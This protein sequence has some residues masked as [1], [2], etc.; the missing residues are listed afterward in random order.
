MLWFANKLPVV[1]CMQSLWHT[2][3]PLNCIFSRALIYDTHHGIS[4]LLQCDKIT[5]MIITLLS[6]HKSKEQWNYLWLWSILM[7][8]FACTRIYNGHSLYGINSRCVRL[9][10]VLMVAVGNG[11]S[12]SNDACMLDAMINITCGN[13]C[14]KTETINAFLH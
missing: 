9:F 4:I 11:S 5:T 12:S 13:W 1:Y 6:G 2:N 7:Y 10:L 3:Y 8:R 14:R